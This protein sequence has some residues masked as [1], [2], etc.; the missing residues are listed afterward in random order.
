MLNLT[1]R[2]HVIAAVFLICSM[3]KAKFK[4][5]RS[6]KISRRAAVGAPQTPMT[7]KVKVDGRTSVDDFLLAIAVD[8]VDNLLSCS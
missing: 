3:T 8:F 6:Q 5:M 4:L 1:I 2:L 7:K